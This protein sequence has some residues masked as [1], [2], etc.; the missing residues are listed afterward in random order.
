MRRLPFA[1]REILR[2]LQQN[3]RASYTDMAATLG[4]DRSTVIVA[5]RRLEMQ[6][7]IK[8]TVGRGRESNSYEVNHDVIHSTK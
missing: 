2:L 6:E 3:Q 8:K 7:R 4:L 1:E 5:V